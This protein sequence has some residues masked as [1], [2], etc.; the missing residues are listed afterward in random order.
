MDDRRAC[1]LLLALFVVLNALCAG[2][3]DRA[4]ADDDKSTGGA[5]DSK[6]S[7]EGSDMASDE[8]RRCGGGGGLKRSA[9]AAS[10]AGLRLGRMLLLLLLL[11]RLLRR[12]MNTFYCKISRIKERERKSVQVGSGAPLLRVLKQKKLRA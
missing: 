7:N 4:G 11:I 3:G 1:K 8:R 12:M 2:R 6:F 10:R 5:C 9:A